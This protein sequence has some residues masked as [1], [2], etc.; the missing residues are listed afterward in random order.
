M[1]C[2]RCERPIDDD[3]FVESRLGSMHEECYDDRLHDTM[4]DSYET[5]DHG[6]SIYP[7]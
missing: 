3:N 4:D 7:K 1:T 5:T 2:V 6:D